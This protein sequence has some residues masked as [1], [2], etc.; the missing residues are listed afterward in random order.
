M[1][2]N[3][4]SHHE[5]VCVIFI[6]LGKYD[7]SMPEDIICLYCM[8][9]IKQRG[10]EAKYRVCGKCR[11]RS[12]ASLTLVAH[13]VEGAYRWLNSH[14]GPFPFL[15]G[16]MTLLQEAPIISELL[17]RTHFPR[18]LEVINNIVEVGKEFDPEQKSAKDHLIIWLHEHPEGLG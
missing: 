4:Y 2:V 8:R 6:N 10:G 15:K 18:G 17:A 3:F 9:L 1:V 7:V 14:E 11:G 12:I 13:A 16:L 5:L